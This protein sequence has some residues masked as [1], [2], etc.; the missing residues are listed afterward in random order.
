MEYEGIAANDAHRDWLDTIADRGV[1]YKAGHDKGYAEKLGGNEEFVEKASKYFS[2]TMVEARRLLGTGGAA[3][4]GWEAFGERLCCAAQHLGRAR[5][6]VRARGAPEVSSGGV[7]DTEARLTTRDIFREKLAR[8]LEL[9]SEEMTR[10]QEEAWARLDTASPP[11]S[12]RRTRSFLQNIQSKLICSTKL[13]KV[14]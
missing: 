5:R 8:R 13:N 4:I 7:R 3:R 10:H 14:K 11:A 9:S 1:M 6:R 2:G 12:T